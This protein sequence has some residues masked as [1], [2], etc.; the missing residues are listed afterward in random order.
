MVH[1]HPQISKCFFLFNYIIDVW[2]EIIGGCSKTLKLPMSEDLK[3]CPIIEIHIF[4]VIPIVEFVKIFL[5]K[6]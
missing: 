2:C 5:E 3:L 4:V 1:H 6:L